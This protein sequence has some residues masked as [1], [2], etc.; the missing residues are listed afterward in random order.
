ML[1]RA[2]PLFNHYQTLGIGF[3]ASAHDIKTAY[4]DLAKKYHPDRN[5]NNPEAEK[6]FREVK[7]AYECL[8]NKVKRADYEKDWVMTGRVRW[9][10]SGEAAKADSGDNEAPGL[11][12][13]EQAILYA[14]VLS[15]PALTALNRRNAAEATTANSA[16][17][18][19][20]AI[21][22]TEI[23]DLAIPTSHEDLV[24]AYYNPLTDR[25]ERLESGQPAP[26]PIEL[27]SYLTHEHK[28]LYQQILRTRSL[29][30]PSKSD[31]LQTRHVPREI[32]V[33]GMVSKMN[34]PQ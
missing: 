19:R 23:P 9:V 29:R 11:T 20:R 28:G 22:W 7:E 25:W 26:T 12:R 6:R 17:E 8:S 13:K 31:V 34:I 16:T 14:I 10:P 18:N 3:R 5:S 1:R 21:S 2:G 15:I 4:R 30:M 24:N 33:E 27:V 32:T